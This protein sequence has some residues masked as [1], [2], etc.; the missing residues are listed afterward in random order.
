MN[1]LGSKPEM[2]PARRARVS[3]VSKAVTGPYARLPANNSRS[4]AAVP[5][6]N[7]EM[8]PMPVTTSAPFAAELDTGVRYHTE[9]IHKTVPIAPTLA[10]IAL[11]AATVFAAQVD[12]V[13]Q[14]DPIDDLF[15]RGRAAQAA[16]KTLTASFTEVTVSTLL[17]DPVIEKGTLV[18][19]LPI[20]VVMTYT[21]PATKTIA[22]DGKRLLVVWPARDVREEI[23]IA[24]IQRRVQRYFVEASLNELRQSF[25]IALSSDAAL[26]NAYLLDMTPKRKQIAEGL[27]RL[28]IWIDRE[29]LVMIRMALEY[30]SGDTKTLALQDVRT[31]VPVDERAFALL[32]RR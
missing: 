6:P 13:P 28:R 8:Q 32:A 17:R 9:T 20:R 4:N 11:M 3:V 12:R 23:D 19:A 26:E 31:N 2:R 1:L 10:A 16:I 7:P 18:A 30:P 22:L 21:S 27:A 14:P 24:G 15:A 29:R 5:T 25:T